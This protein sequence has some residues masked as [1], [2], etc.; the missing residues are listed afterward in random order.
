ME[1]AFERQ[2][3]ANDK[4]LL[5]DLAFNVRSEETSMDQELATLH[6]QRSELE[7]RN[8]HLTGELQNMKNKYEELVSEKDDLKQR[9]RDLERASAQAAQS[10]KSDFLVRTEIDNL[11]YNL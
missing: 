1:K 9:I 4:S 10:G 6:E 5:L 11:R 8:Q 2:L 7:R 3:T